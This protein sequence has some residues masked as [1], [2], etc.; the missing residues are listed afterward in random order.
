MGEILYK[1]LSYE[2]VGCFYNVRNK[3][4]NFHKEKI[5]HKALIEELDLKRIKFIF[6]PKINL[7]SLTTSKMISYYKPDFLI[8]GLILVEIKALPFTKKE[9]I[10]QLFEYLKISE[11]EL[12]YLVNFGE[13]KFEPKR[14]IHTKDR[15]D[16]LKL[17]ISD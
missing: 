15:K 8:D 2:L 9:N 16:F 6:E 1:E 4:G 12:A 13:Q 5:Y 3:Y 11:Y 7:Y 14:F 17:K 10:M